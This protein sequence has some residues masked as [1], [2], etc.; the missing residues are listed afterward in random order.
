MRDQ[1]T[2]APLTARSSGVL[3]PIFSLPSRFGIGDLGTCAYRF[4]DRLLAAG[5]QYWQV[6]PLDPPI[7]GAGG[8]PYSSSSS[9]AGNPLLIDLNA[10]AEEELL[11]EAELNPPRD[12]PPQ[13][14]DY[15]IVT[16]FKMSAL[17]TASAR[18][19]KGGGEARFE[20]MPRTRGRGMPRP[21]G[22]GQ[23]GFE[24]FC[25]QQ[26]RWLED[27]ALF[28]AL[29][30]ENPAQSWTDWPQGLRDR[31][32][33]ALADARGRLAGE[34][35]HWRILQYLFFRQWR[36]L[37]SYCNER[38]LLIFG[39]MPIYSNLESADV[40]SNSGIYQLDADKRP[41]AVSGVPPDY[42]SP[43]GQLW[44]N[45]LYDW[46]ELQRQGFAW[47]I[48]RMG[49]LFDRFDLVR[50]DHFRGLVQCWEVPVPC[51]NAMH[52]NWR[53]VPT[54]E[55]FD[56]LRSASPRFPVVAEDLGTISPDVV[57]TR[58]HYGLPGMLV[59]QF[60]FVDDHAD[61]PY[62][63]RNHRE[64]AV[65]YLGT[66]DNNTARGWLEEECDEAV[67]RRLFSH[68]PHSE[69]VGET[70]FRLLELVMSSSA[71]TA[72]ISVQDLLVLPSRARINVPGTTTGNWS[73]R[74]SEEE[75]DSIDW[76]TLNKLSRQ[77][78]RI[79]SGE[80]CLARD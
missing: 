77:S 66:H 38:G 36:R 48:E 24:E 28:T 72:I 15:E 68:T 32:P 61:N 17:R 47:W 14:I 23:T 8:S 4:A 67:K 73:W 63:P 42:F 58:D 18:F 19:A 29:V 9:F 7:A 16:R 54:H 51:E 70:V 25:R 20:E 34:I 76:D 49:A 27:Y 13:E 65:V 50:I 45:P 3:L 37:K 6:L 30:E 40:W 78:G 75:F 5:Q 64:N 46:Q 52:G 80:A 44:N 35:E 55:L 43:E 53:Q 71:R 62:L 69:D 41:S 26:R 21:Y 31:E 56:A 12:L 57:Q 1:A 2:P 22:E 11:T 59:M 10:L 79:R 33:A 74:L 60:A 39:D